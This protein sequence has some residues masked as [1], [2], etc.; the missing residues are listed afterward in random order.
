MDQEQIDEYLTNIYYS[1]NHPASFGGVDKIYNFVKTSGQPIS[2]GRIAKWLRTQDNS[3]KHK[4]VRRHFKRRRVV[5]PRKFYQFDSDTISMIRFAKYNKGYKYILV[6]IDILSRFCWAAPLKSLTGKETAEALK[7]LLTRPPK[8]LRTDGGSEYINSNVKVYLSSKQIKHIQTLN[9]TKANFAERLIQTI[10]NK[11]IKYLD[12]KETSE[13]VTVLPEIIHS[14]NHTYH[15]SIKRTPAQALDTDDVTLWKIQYSLQKPLLKKT[16][17]KLPRARS[18]FKFKVGDTVKLSFISSKF[19]RKYDQTWSDEYFTVTARFNR[20]D[21]G[22]YRVKD[23]SND[24]VR[25]LFY[26]SEMTKVSVKDDVEYKIEKVIKYRKR[27]GV[28]QALVKWVG[29]GSKF[30]SYIDASTIKEKSRI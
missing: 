1:P 27:N 11:I 9:E 17:G 21:I 29:W 14:Y 28:K 4:P 10:K 6:L 19:D 23:W 18:A 24:P 20:E 16:L 15:R 26:E 8:H 2:K 25:G 22:Q 3:T 5:V 12:F 30:N 7:T 13:W